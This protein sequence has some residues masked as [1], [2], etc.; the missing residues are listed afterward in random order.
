MPFLPGGKG[1]RVHSLIR[2]NGARPA[3]RGALPLMLTVAFVFF[4]FMQRGAAGTESYVGSVQVSI[5]VAQPER[6][7][8]ADRVAVTP[9]DAAAQAMGA[10]H[11]LASRTGPTVPHTTDGRLRPEQAEAPQTW[12]EIAAAAAPLQ[13]AYRSAAQASASTRMTGT[14][15]APAAVNERIGG[16]A[17]SVAHS[18][19]GGRVQGAAVRVRGTAAAQA[20]NLYATI[21]GPGTQ[22]QRGGVGRTGSDAGVES[23][24]SA[25]VSSAR[26]TSSHVCP[27]AWQVEVEGTCA[28]SRW[29]AEYA[30]AGADNTDA[31]E[32]AHS[33]SE[34]E[35]SGKHLAYFSDQGHYGLAI[36][37]DSAAGVSAVKPERPVSEAART[38]A[39]SIT[40]SESARAGVITAEAHC[41]AYHFDTS[42]LTVI[43]VSCR[44][45]ENLPL[46]HSILTVTLPAGWESIR[47][48]PTSVG[49]QVGVARN[50]KGLSTCSIDLED[51]LARKEEVV[52]RLLCDATGKPSA[53]PRHIEAHVTSASPGE[54]GLAPVSEERLEVSNL[55][56]VRVEVS[57]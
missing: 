16:C 5:E 37:P 56:V 33:V 9:S 4:V 34:I 10:P 12:E 55:G 1:C 57:Q 21:G 14:E 41:S 50:E 45:A 19:S 15:T 51:A 23:L 53:V 20:A 36:G 22:V 35:A 32:A 26:S 8:A 3:I 6:V 11:G 28:D 39:Q 24:S 47:L 13:A 31:A 52:V 17:L 2:G 29:G 27:L 42:G 7:R 46:E 18:C 30:V 38:S 48:A 25:Y 40:T 44:R 49:R 43:L 54:R